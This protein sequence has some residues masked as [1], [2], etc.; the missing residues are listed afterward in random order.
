MASLP[1]GFVLDTE[2]KS[3]G[4]PD[5]FMLDGESDQKD[6]AAALTDVGK[7][8]RREQTE[9]S[10]QGGVA[11]SIFYGSQGGYKGLSDFVG[12]PVDATVWA[13]NKGLS[14]IPQDQ[15][16]SGLV[17]GAEPRPYQI[18]NPYFGSEHIRNVMNSGM[19]A[20]KEATGI[21]NP[22]TPMV[23]NN[24]NEV[25]ENFR[26][27]ARFGEVS[28]STLPMLA[29]P[30]MAAS[31]APVSASI[32]NASIPTGSVARDLTRQVVADAASNPSFVASQLPSTLGSATG[33][34]LAE[35]V[36]PGSE[37]AQVVGQIGGGLMGG[38]LTAAADK[39]SSAVG[40][41]V[42][43]IT[44]PFKTQTETGARDAA[45]RAL[46]PILEQSGESA[47]S[48]INRLREQPVVPGLVSGERAQSPALTG[49]Q[50]VLSKESPELANAIDAGR[51]EFDANLRQGV[52]NAFEPGNQAA[53]AETA[54]KQAEQF[55][56]NLDDLVASAEKRA[57]DTLS[58][59]QPNNP[60]QR[61][62]LN[63]KARNILEEALTKAR[64]QE[65]KLWADVPKDA[66]LS[67]EKSVAA[68]NK[69]KEELLPGESLGPTIEKATQQLA[70]KSNFDWNTLSQETR[71]EPI[72]MGYALK[73]RSSI[74]E[75]ARA[76]RA[77]ND[78]KTARRL[79]VLADGLLD[80]MSVVGGEATTLARDYSRQLNDRF[81]RSFAGDILGTKPT[82]A[83]KVRPE[84]TLESAATGGGPTVAQ[85][86]SE[87]RTAGG[88]G[89]GATQEQFLRSMSERVFDPST[90]KIKANAVDGFLRDNAAILDQFP[91]YRAQLEA[92]RDAQRGAET[93]I[94]RT[95]GAAKEANKSAA[96]AKVLA[97]GE[98]PASAVAGAL[99][100]ANPQRDLAKLSSLARKGGEEAIGG[101]RASVLEHVFEQAGKGGTF[102]Y[103]KVDQLLNAPISSKGGSLLSELRQNGI[104]NASQH[105]EIKRLVDAGLADEINKITGL[106]VKS[107][108]TDV[109]D[110]ARYGSRVIGARIASA[111]D[112]GGSGAGSSLQAAAIG[113]QV[114][115][116]LIARLPGDKARQV[117]IDA[118]G[119]KDPTALID[120]L[121]RA[122]GSAP[123]GMKAIPKP[124]RELL[125]TL[126]AMIPR[127]KSNT[128]W[129]Q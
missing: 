126:R 71:A 33:A 14:L 123:G 42:N 86:M 105:A 79:G 99:G 128:E 68:F 69:I 19:R 60:G 28:G 84:L 24:I 72:S 100:G 115:E 43:A 26:A 76:A 32:A 50:R 120:I 83:D 64:E 54:K 75:D 6:R 103:G 1:E 58:S 116:K 47:A 52:R 4:L 16:M 66:Q 95:S 101:L 25:P 20:A 51:T 85:K 96:F 91:Q 77:S 80:D 129:E 44:G 5:G 61:E 67:T 107:V 108:G 29:L 11:N 124:T 10:K 87:L 56:G 88:E 21:G 111:I 37:N 31:R 49:A 59:V 53:L 70:P 112:L 125:V 127:D 74:L 122:A 114:A 78:F 27:A 48:I 22:N 97:A 13:L 98:N 104:I 34:Y 57:A 110:M 9:P 118:L 15:T 55:T 18:K 40:R 106:Q 30:I 73:L 38:A 94:A 46:R 89:M 3:G 102:S 109:T 65:S 23:Y 113:A 12:A 17:T 119:S 2:T 35:S 92:A 81:N 90:G 39:G 45:G 36:A 62:A 63:V 7:R 8:F 117:L 93:V 82:G 41:M 121:E